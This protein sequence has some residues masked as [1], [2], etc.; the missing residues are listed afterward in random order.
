MSSKRDYYEVMDLDR[1]ASEQDIKSAYRKLALKYHPDRNPGDHQAENHFK[2]AAEA[3]SVL[4]D[5]QK[6]SQYDRF[7]HAGVSGVGGPGAG[8]FDPSTFSDFSDILGDLFG[9]GDLFGGGAAG[10]DGPRTEVPISVTISKSD[11]KRRRLEKRPESRFRAMKLVP[12]VAVR[13]PPRAVG[14]RPVRR[15]TDTDRCGI[16]R[17]SFRSRARVV[18][19][20][21]A[22]SS[23]RNAVGSATAK[24][25]S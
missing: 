4:S 23:S 16:S 21:E 6:R 3:Y 11:L 9:F 22:G 17:G 19:V 10:A 1:G 7:G 12:S 8:G 2:E 14:R 18:S 25:V 24:A 13:V 20:K 15:A 5:P